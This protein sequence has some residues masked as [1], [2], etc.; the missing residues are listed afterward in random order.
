[1]SPIIFFAAGSPKG[2]PRVRAFVR[3]NHAGVYDPGTANEFKTSIYLSS[4]NI[5]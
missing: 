4:L 1:M 2:Q 5:N 3:G